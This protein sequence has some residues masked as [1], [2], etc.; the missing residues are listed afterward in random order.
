MEKGEELYYVDRSRWRKMR[1][2]ITRRENERDEEDRRREVYE[3]EQERRR[4]E[5]EEKQKK[6]NRVLS[7]ETELAK[8]AL[9]PTKFNFNLPIKRNTNLGG[10][11]DDDDDEDGNK[12]RRVL[13]PLDYSDIEVQ[14]TEDLSEISTE[15]RA[16]RVKQLIDSIP[17]S[18]QDLWSYQVKW[19]EL[20]EVCLFT[21][22][23]HVLIFKKLTPL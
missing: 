3:I 22:H 6:D 10:G 4:A 7:R 20:D 8:I 2:A 11:D 1:E 19:D 18:Q 13:I 5:E 12:K 15:E 9:K 16:K 17:S 21:L 14:Q 23:I